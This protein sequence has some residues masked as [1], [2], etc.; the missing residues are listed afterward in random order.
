MHGWLE[1]EGGFDDPKGLFLFT[2]DSKPIPANPPISTKPTFG[3]LDAFF[4]VQFE[5]QLL[6]SA[7]NLWFFFSGHG[8]RGPGG[9]YLMLSDSHPGGIERT[10]LPVN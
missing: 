4:D 7:D 5:R 6:T 1:E 2:E 8:M 10:A 9:D 3:H